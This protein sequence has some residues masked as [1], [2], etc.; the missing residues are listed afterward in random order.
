[1]A[2]IEFNQIIR[3]IFKNP[4]SSTTVR[5][6]NISQF[7]KGSQKHT[8]NRRKMKDIRTSI[9][10]KNLFFSYIKFKKDTYDTL[11]KKNLI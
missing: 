7:F 2:E 8:Q 4:F 5:Q 11:I 9:I 1:M 3:S 6:S 10:K